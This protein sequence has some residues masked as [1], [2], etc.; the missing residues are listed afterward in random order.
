MN[1]NSLRVVMTS[2]TCRLPSRGPVCS[3]QADMVLNPL[4][5]QLSGNR[6]ASCWALEGPSCLICKPLLTS[7]RVFPAS[8]G[9]RWT[10]VEWCS[11][12]TATKSKSAWFAASICEVT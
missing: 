5:T 4:T 6:S 7:T 1:A 8:A 11:G 10:N 2:P 12:Y 3:V 9:F